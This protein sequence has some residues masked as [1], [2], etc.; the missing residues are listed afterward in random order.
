MHSTNPRSLFPPREQEKDHHC[1]STA[2][3][4]SSCFPPLGI[5][6]RFVD[7]TLSPF[8]VYKGNKISVNMP[9]EEEQ[10]FESLSM[11]CRCFS[12]VA[13]RRETYSSSCARPSWM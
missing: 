10:V 13:W 3:R 11:T 5:F 1:H 7:H 12:R 6:P 8:P 2:E 9:F 4:S